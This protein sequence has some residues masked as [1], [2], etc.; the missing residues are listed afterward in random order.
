MKVETHVVSQMT[1]LLQFRI[2][3]PNV[4]LFFDMQ[5]F[6]LTSFEAFLNKIV[7]HHFIGRNLHYRADRLD[8][9]NRHNRRGSLYD[10][11]RLYD[12]TCRMLNVLLISQ[13]SQ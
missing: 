5:A 11:G 8:F 1:S 6:K 7:I 13:F 10:K 2:Q 12:V 4:S 3:W 9:H